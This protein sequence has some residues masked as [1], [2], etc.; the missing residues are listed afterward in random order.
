MFGYSRNSGVPR[1]YGYSEALNRVKETEPIRGRQ[2]EPLLPLGHR[3]SVDSYSIRKRKDE[4]VECV[5]YHTPIIVFLPDNTVQVGAGTWNSTSDAYFI[6]EVMGFGARI[7]DNSLCIR[8][9][10]GEYRVPKNGS[11]I[12]KRT[13]SGVWAALNS[14]AGKTH[15]LVRHEANNVRNKYKAFAT[16]GR[17]LCNLKSDSAFDIAEYD[18]VF[19]KADEV[20]CPKEPFDLNNVSHKGFVDAAVNFMGLIEDVNP[21]TQHLSFYKASLILAKSFGDRFYGHTSN[22]YMPSGYKFTATQFK[23]GLERMIFGANRDKVFEEVELPLGVTRKDSH[24]RF[25]NQ[26]WSDL[27]NKLA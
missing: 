5:L 23:K 11:L 27:V 16:Y 4:A 12:I 9:D 7:F 21:N 1:L 14:A 26:T 2:A 15:R 10:G 17:G 13:V 8:L 20:D 6:S 19:G 18:E 3:R 25:F 24:E 22:G